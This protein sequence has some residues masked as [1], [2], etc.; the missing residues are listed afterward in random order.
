M[1]YLKKI[2]YMNEDVLVSYDYTLVDENSKSLKYEFSDD[3][4]NNF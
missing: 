1:K 2:K 4:G 3:F